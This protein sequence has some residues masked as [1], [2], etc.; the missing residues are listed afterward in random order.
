MF[1]Q[2]EAE[3]RVNAPG[4]VI[5]GLKPGNYFW[6]VTAIDAQR[7]ESD[8]SETRQFTL[9]AKGAAEMLL[10]IDQPKLHGNV[11]EITGRTEPG[12]TLLIH[13]QTV[14]N[15]GADGRFQFFTPPLP[16]GSQVIK[17][18]GQNRRGSTVN[19]DVPIVIP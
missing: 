15:I 2:I 16:R 12:A 18:V 9:Y 1:N 6:V 13:G 11:V 17:I 10:E 8:A 3:K 5:T 4:A 19:R 14:P 7:G